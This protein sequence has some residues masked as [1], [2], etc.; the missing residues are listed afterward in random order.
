MK[1]KNQLLR[2]SLIWILLYVIA[3]SAAETFSDEL[4][5]YSSV[6]LPVTIIFAI[7]L[8]VFVKKKNLSEEIG[9]CPNAKLAWS[10]SLHCLYIT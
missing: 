4:G 1:A 5:I 3:M 9:L 6:T 8:Y 7:V 2:V 10:S